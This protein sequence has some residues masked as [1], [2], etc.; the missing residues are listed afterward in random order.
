MLDTTYVKKRKRKRIILIIS[1]IALIGL[2]ILSIIAL[3]SRQAGAFTVSLK[4]GTTSLALSL[5]EACEDPSTYLTTEKASSYVESTYIQVHPDKSVNLDDETVK[6]PSPDR[7]SGTVPYF[8]ITF[9]VVN[10]GNNSADYTFNLNLET[11]GYNTTQLQGLESVLRVE[12]YENRNLDEHNSKIYALRRSDAMAIDSNGQY[13]EQQ[14]IISKTYPITNYDEEKKTETYVLAEPFISAKKV[15]TS[16]IEDLKA[17]EKVRYTFVF[18]VEGTDPDSHDVP[19]N[20]TLRLRANILAEEHL[21]D[22][23]PEPEP[24]PSTGA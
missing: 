10:V 9:Y 23:T 5:T 12:C 14:D 20:N 2:I 1:I 24:T 17:G 3:L 7:D 19:P 18:W 21:E 13:V 8:K 6:T 16:K 15:L 4:Q 11:I 22:S